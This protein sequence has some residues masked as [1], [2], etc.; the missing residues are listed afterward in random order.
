M[1]NTSYQIKITL[2]G[3]RPP[4][5]RRLL[6][7]ADCTMDALHC[8]IQR[9]MGWQDCHLYAFRTRNR[10][11]EIPDPDDM[12]DSG[13]SNSPKPEDAAEIRLSDVARP[14]DKLTY[15]YDFGDG[16]MHD[17]L[18][19]KEIESDDITVRKAVCVKGKRACPPEDC[20]GIW[21]Y[22]NL[23]E[24]LSTPEQ[25]RDENEKEFVEWAGGEWDAEAFDQNA[26]N[27]ALEHWLP[28]HQSCMYVGIC[29]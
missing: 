1:K 26:I 16:W 18:I 4:I 13:W 24:S 12:W 2:K 28:N 3:M 27:R 23:L 10:R 15:E 6:I 14:G 25:E 29:G 9:S 21:G 7:S 22:Q 20:G 5:W 8:A 19:E 17:I 11:I